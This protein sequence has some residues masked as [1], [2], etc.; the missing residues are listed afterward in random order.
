MIK[1]AFVRPG[2]QIEVV[3]TAFD[4]PLVVK[5]RTWMPMAQLLTWPIMARFAKNRLPDRTWLQA[6]G[7]GALT[8][9]F[10]L[11][12][13]WCH[14]LAHAAAAHWIG[15]PMD[16][17]RILW[18]MPLVIY[19]DINAQDVKP[20][21]HIARALG[22]PLFNLL[23]TPFAYLFWRKSTPQSPAHDIAGAALATNLFIPVVG[24]L[25]IPFIDGGPILKWSLVERGR[26]IPEAD[27]VVRKVNGLLG[28]ILVL[29]GRLAF[30][31][32]RRLAGGFLLALAGWA[33]AF[34]LGLMKE[35]AE[36]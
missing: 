17:I 32:R 31:K 4:T 19:N 35:Q 16:A 10:V 36:P 26:S 22:G 2:D 12:S 7:V 3:C 21:E 24:L 18:G 11:G 15:K 25:P 6:L 23:L 27:R 34:G 28:L 14:N 9:P 5:G 29:A 1:P 30:K 20:K 33:L 8:M 13:E